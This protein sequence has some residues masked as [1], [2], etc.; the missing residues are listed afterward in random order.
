MKSNHNS[1][2]L[3]VNFLS[4]YTFHMKCAPGFHILSSR[5]AARKAF[6]GNAHKATRWEVPAIRPDLV[7]DQKKGSAVR[8]AALRISNSV[9]S[10]Y[11]PKD[12]S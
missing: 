6:P 8:R 7:T 10:P 5:R 1:C 2:V 9:P 12:Q 11:R 3:M 4:E